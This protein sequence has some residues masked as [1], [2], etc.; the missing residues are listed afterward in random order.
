LTGRVAAD[1]PRRPEQL[2]A[3]VGPAQVWW[4]SKIVTAADGLVSRL[5]EWRESGSEI[6]TTSNAALRA[7]YM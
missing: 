5:R 1:G 3:A 2:D 6:Q 4:E 7:K